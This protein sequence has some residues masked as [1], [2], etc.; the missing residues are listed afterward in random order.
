M[1]GGEHTTEYTKV[2]LQYCASEF[3]VMLL[4]NATSIKKKLLVN[5]IIVT[6]IGQNQFHL[7][8]IYLHFYKQKSLASTES[9]CITI[10][11]YNLKSCNFTTL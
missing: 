11:F 10:S 7:H 2:E 6:S 3:Y 5:A 8:W 4:T 1:F 9:T